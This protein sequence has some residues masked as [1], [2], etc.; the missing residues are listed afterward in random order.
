MSIILDSSIEGSLWCSMIHMSN[1]TKIIAQFLLVQ[2]HLHT[3]YWG[4]SAEG[5]PCADV[6]GCVV[7][8]I[9]LE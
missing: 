8:T 6:E 9:C 7:V 5:T 1:H 2:H 4:T 3:P